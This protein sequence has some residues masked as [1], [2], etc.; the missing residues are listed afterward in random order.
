MLPCKL[1]K[2]ISYPTSSSARNIV[3]WP[4]LETLRKIHKC[5][6]VYKCLRNFVPIYLK[7]YFKVNNDVHLY[8]IITL[9]RGEIF[10]QIKQ[11]LF[12]GGELLRIQDV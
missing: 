4:V 6:L 8:T 7:N 10:T 2:I 5:I 11:I 3:N 12:L 1:A 9:G